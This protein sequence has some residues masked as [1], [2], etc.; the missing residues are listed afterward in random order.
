MMAIPKTEIRDNDQNI[1]SV[2][3]LTQEIKILLETGLPTLWVEGEVSNY[4]LHSSGHMYFVLKDENAQINCTMWRSRNQMLYFNLQDGIKVQAQGRITVYEKRGSYQLD[5]VQI[6]PAGVG[7]LQL[8]FELLKKK[9]R[10]EGLFEASRKKPL[11]RY[12]ERI[13]IVTSATG[14]AIRDLVSILH[15][16]FPALELILRPTL[17]QGEGAAEDIAN[18][19]DEFNA[20]GQVDVLIVGRGGGSLEDLWA[21]NEE[22]VARAIA[23]SKIP[24]I[25]AVGH[26]VDFTI[27]DFV[28]D[29]RAPTPSA[30]AE[31]VV[32][33]KSDLSKFIRLKTEKMSRRLTDKIANYQEKLRYIRSGY[34]F[35]RPADITRQFQQRLDELRHSLELAQQHRLDLARKHLELLTQR[36][37]ALGP[38]SIL[39]RGYSICFTANDGQ[40][41]RTAAM[42]NPNQKIRI[43]FGQGAL[44]GTADTIHPDDS[45]TDTMEKLKK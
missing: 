35:R 15:R 41:V 1:Y 42:L 12:P 8:A 32:K 21:F 9:L 28:A 4:K 40:L 33:D 7:N 17:V 45:L 37:L 31:L 25:S 10:E 38:E 22:M 14:A 3:E 19:I 13:G 34:G 16:R 2:S 11:P 5:V 26:E 44:D 27:C 18:A 39:N 20:F 6:R 24:I 29:L 23:R 43:Q 30:A 36:L